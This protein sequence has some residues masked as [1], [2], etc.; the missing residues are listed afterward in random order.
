MISASEFQASL[1]GFLAD[2]GKSATLQRRSGATVT[3]SALLT[4]F[5]RGYTPDELV[6]GTGII[7][8]D[9]VVIVSQTDLT[10]AGWVG[11]IH[12]NDF[13]L[14]DGRTTR[15]IAAAVRPMGIGF[16]LQVRG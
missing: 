9:S 1:D 11:S 4:V 10:N 14:V 6:A 16:D 2:Y 7:Q 12:A 13:L 15:V 3:A 8:G 5:M